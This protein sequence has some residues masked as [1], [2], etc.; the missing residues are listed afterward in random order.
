M[1][2]R[3]K[4]YVG[5]AIIVALLVT[6][7]AAWQFVQLYGR[8]IE[9]SSFRSF[10]VSGRGKAV[11]VPDVAAFT[12]SVVTQGG[13]DVESLQS[14]NTD[15]MNRAID[16][17]KQQGVDAKDITTQN[18]NIDPR[19][20]YYNCS[21]GGSATPCPPPDI[22]GYTVTQSVQVKI[23]DFAKIG[24]ILSGVVK[25]GANSVSQLS[26][27]I[28]DPTS[29]QNAARAEAI[30]KAKAQAKSIAD[31]AGFTLGQL[32]SIQENSTPL[33]QPYQYDM[34]KMNFEAY[35]TGGAAPSVE[36]GSQDI[37]ENVTLTYE[38]R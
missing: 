2:T 29:V 16:F 10:S 36:A 37:V 1:N 17:V 28:D 27:T 9:P 14:Q 13:K 20:Q 5:V 11:A 38:I 6:A 34:R 21:Q 15:K 19:Y 35:R 33:P 30:E 4:D 24:D 31:T 32:L 26:F 12:F 3:I 8:R 18:Y 22:A 25:N 23:R 7:L